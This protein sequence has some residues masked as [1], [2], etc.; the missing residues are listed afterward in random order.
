MVTG[1]VLIGVVV[2]VVLLVICIRGIQG[3]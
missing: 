3:K 1:G 2:M